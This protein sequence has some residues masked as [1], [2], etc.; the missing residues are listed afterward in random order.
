MP[1]VYTIFT[2][3]YEVDSI[4]NYSLLLYME[5]FYVSQI[6]I[7]NPFFSDLILE[8]SHVL[9]FPSLRIGVYFQVS[10]S[11]THA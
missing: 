8:L 1:A 11:T 9:S 5:L 2:H 4:F 3:L 10:H 6:I 7:R